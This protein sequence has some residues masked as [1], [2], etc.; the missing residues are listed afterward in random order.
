[1]WGYLKISQHIICKYQVKI[2]KVQIS[3]SERVLEKCSVLCHP[4]A[5]RLKSHIRQLGQI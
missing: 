1:M 2:S 4:L 5:F 3:Q